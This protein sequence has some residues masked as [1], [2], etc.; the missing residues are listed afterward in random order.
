MAGMRTLRQSSAEPLSQSSAEPLRQSSAEPL[1]QNSAGLPRLILAVAL[2][3]AV[4]VAMPVAA[5]AATFAA[6][7]TVSPPDAAA[8]VAGDRY[9]G[10]PLTEAASVAAEERRLIEVRAI[11]NTAGWT[12]ANEGDPYRLVTGNTYTLVL[13]RRDNPYT[14]DDLLRYAP[15]TFVQQPDGSYLLTENIVVERGATLELSS[16]QPRVLRLA[17]TPDAFVSIVTTGGALWL[18]GSVDSP[19]E[20]TSWDPVSQRVDSDTADGRA[21]VRVIGGQAAF[22]HVRFHDLGFW[23]GATGGVSLTG[24]A[25]PDA[26]AQDAA[27]AEA[28]VFDT[29]V[30]PS[31]GGA[32][33]L[34]VDADLSAYSS[35]SAVLDDVGSTGNAFGMFISSTSGVEIRNSTFENNLVDGLVLHRG[36]TN[37]V[38]QD[39]SASRNGVDGVSV[40]RGATGVALERITADENGRN[41]IRLA[42]GPLADGPSAT[43]TTTARYGNNH[44]SNSRL[45]ANG[46]YGIE[47]V[48][49]VDFVV[50]GNV[51][52]G[53]E[54]GIVVAK[55][56]TG[57]TIT[58]NTV[59]N[60]GVHAIA[61]RDGVTDAVVQDNSVA[62]ASVGI[63]LR[64]S[65]GVID[66]NT[67][68]DVD[69]HAITLIGDAATSTISYN[70]LSGRGPSAIDVA[71]ADREPI[72]SGND[73]QSWQETKP[74]EVIVRSIFQPLTVMWIVLG[75]AVVIT[76]F[77]SLRRR[78][79]RGVI[80]HPY[81]SHR[82]LDELTPGVADPSALRRSG[83][84]AAEKRMA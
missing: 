55:A 84:T 42:G 69:N 1:R 63:F 14:L 52:S 81:E 7:T 33:L 32:A 70:I 80:R 26:P 2:G 6:S 31:D 46:R 3:V 44:V 16:D 54:M 15:S 71:R 19:L 61:L 5:Q 29:D 10:D 66:H 24:T 65:S 72:L 18:G 60:S 56:V 27:A 8:A 57:V 48:G 23:S 45:A 43:G 67:V 78:R 9:P 13:V 76:A 62:G 58:H 73:A 40:L 59:E 37:A 77:L 49:G 20:V 82:P 34:N 53:H 21:Y 28:G 79:R 35:V 38:V 39:T 51:V 83:R 30:Y 64:D 12:D 22:A 47:L 41:G 50:D 74:L 75:A 17:S 25:A 68:A 11:G 4:A 36:V